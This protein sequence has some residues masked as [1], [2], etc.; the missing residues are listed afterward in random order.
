MKSTFAAR[1]YSVVL[2]SSLCL[3]T[4]AFAAV[5]MVLTVSGIEGN[6]KLVPGGI[7]VVSYSHGLENIM[8]IRT[9]SALP[10]SGG[11]AGKAVF[12]EFTV[13]AGVDKATPLLYKACASGTPNPEVVLYVRNNPANPSYLVIKLEDVLVSSVQMNGSRGGENLGSVDMSF[14][15]GTITTTTVFDGIP[16]VFTAIVEDQI[17]SD[18]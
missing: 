7:E 8:D 2:V 1:L 17:P 11:G 6:S 16:E 3:A 5:D 18:N 4:P 10:G 13:Q 14:T 9:M 12:K 15:Y